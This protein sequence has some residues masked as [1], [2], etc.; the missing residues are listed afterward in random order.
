L[1]RAKGGIYV[2]PENPV[3]LV[4]ALVQLSHYPLLRRPFG[5]NGSRYGFSNY[6]RG[7]S[8]R[9]FEKLLPTS[10]PTRVMQS[11]AIES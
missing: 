8:A 7:L 2:E 5:E 4:G 3:A 1:Q 11:T 6:D 10:R 9:R